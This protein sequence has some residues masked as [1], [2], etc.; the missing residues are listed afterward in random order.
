MSRLTRLFYAPLALLLCLLLIPDPAAAQ[1]TDFSGTWVYNQSKSDQPGGGARGRMGTPSDM[2]ITQEGN[3][4]A[5]E[6]MRQSRQGEQKVTEAII[7]D[8]EPHESETG[9]GPAT[10]TANWKDGALVVERTR[11]MSRGGQTRTFT[12]TSTYVLSEDGKELVVEM[13]MPNPQ[14]GTLIRRSVY[15]KKEL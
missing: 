3:N 13:E 5:I 12:Q 2:T 4:I 1:A 11:T 7:V 6:T 15:N 9:F 10:I 8:G 14:G